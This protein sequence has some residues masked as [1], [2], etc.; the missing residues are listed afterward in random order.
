MAGK[1]GFEVNLGA[2]G[3]PRDGLLRRS[4]KMRI[5]VLGDFSG[6]HNRGLETT[7]DL[8]GRAI[9]PVDLDRFDAVF[10][11]LSPSLS[12]GTS[13]AATAGLDVKFDELEDFHP[14]RLYAA[15]E[16]FGRL[17]ESRARLLDPATFE[18]ESSR[19]M[20]G[21][22]S[23]SASTEPGPA[24][25]QPSREDQAGL[26]QRLIGAPAEPVPRVSS[27][28]V[29]DG[30]IRRLVQPHIKPGTSRSPAPYIAALDASSTE[31]M[32]GL[33]HDADFQSLE[34]TWR[35][36]RKLV[37]S[38]ELGD[39]L[40]LHIVDVSKGELLADLE[41]S[42]GNPLQSAA[43]RLL[44]ESSR[45][46]ADEQPWSLLV[47]HYSFGANAADLALLGHLGVIASR[48][49]GP[50]MAAAEPG[51]VGCER[52]SEATEPRQWAF[53]D[54]EIEKAW[55]DLR[56]SPAARWLALAMPRI[57]LRLPYGA[58][59]DPTDSFAF[60]E[61]S[62]SSGHEAY[63]WGNAA[64]ACAQ[65]IAQ[66]FLDEG[67]SLSI[68]GPLELDDLPAHIRDQ[69]GERRLQACAEF[70]LPVRVGEELL[71]RGMT[72]LLSYGN[73]NAVRVLRIQ[74]IAEPLHALAGLG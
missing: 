42:Q 65:G 11:R 62:P 72:P 19:L 20:E 4:D 29:V 61:F 35:G 46:G 31:L 70:T 49:G 5:L 54:P 48:A 63:L 71:Q 28:G 1:F 16:P 17:R 8:A 37:E 55:N 56:R 59:S 33:L 22:P 74:S 24:A 58:K 53:S 57:L 40:T 27:Q 18:Q 50:L 10:R 14:D 6:R 26:L 44:V 13:A 2:A 38:L 51:L 7:A 3:A 45:R 21:Q 30:L 66:G 43:H 23:A 15:L 41:T 60:E 25:G 12:L 32:R 52:L 64:L 67:S 34:A 47:G 39:E 69:D 68:A 73:R 36:V 9:L